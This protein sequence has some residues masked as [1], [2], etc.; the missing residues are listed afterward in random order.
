MLVVFGNE[1]RVLVVNISRVDGAVRRVPNEL[2]LLN[3]AE[4]E[5]EAYVKED[6]AL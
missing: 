6:C 3:S 5:V 2:L 4:H 1:L